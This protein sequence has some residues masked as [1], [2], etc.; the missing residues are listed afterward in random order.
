MSLSNDTC[1]CLGLLPGLTIEQPCAKRDTCLRYVERWAGGERTPRAQ[2]LCPGN[3]EYYE[4][5]IP[6]IEKGDR[7]A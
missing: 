4:M 3:N 5:Y 1:R 6:T 2:W 7:R